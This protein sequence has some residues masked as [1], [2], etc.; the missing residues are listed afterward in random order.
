MF[1]DSVHTSSSLQRQF[2]LPAERAFL[3]RLA[4]R[5]VPTVPNALLAFAAVPYILLLSYLPLL[6]YHIKKITFLNN[7]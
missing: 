5:L 2:P 1:L 7:P 4:A 6:F 3:E